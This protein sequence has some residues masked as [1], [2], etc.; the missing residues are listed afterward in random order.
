MRRGH[1]FQPMS[2]RTGNYQLAIVH[3]VFE[4]SIC[5]RK[6]T[7]KTSVVFEFAKKYAS[8]SKVKDE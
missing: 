1:P 6:D 5:V 2:C 4:F 7:S 3:T 8:K